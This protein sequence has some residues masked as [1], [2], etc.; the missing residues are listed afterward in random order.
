MSEE[1][2]EESESDD[3]SDFASEASDE[4]ME[5]EELSDSGDGK[6]LNAWINAHMDDL[7]FLDLVDWDELEEKARKGIYKLI[8][9]EIP[10]R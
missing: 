6:W 4:S 7:N 3:E 1:E 8:R 2:F 10:W 5:E 9:V